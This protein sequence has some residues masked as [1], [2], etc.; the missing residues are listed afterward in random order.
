M[1]IVKDYL[2]REPDEIE[3]QFYLN[4]IYSHTISINKDYFFSSIKEYLIDLAKANN[5][6][7]AFT[8]QDVDDIYESF[9]EEE[10]FYTFSDQDQHRFIDEFIKER[11]ITIK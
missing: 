7:K 2:V 1:K 3:V 9:D 4:D 10:Y 5:D 6:Y 8:Y 11:V